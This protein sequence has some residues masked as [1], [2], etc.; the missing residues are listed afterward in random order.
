MEPRRYKTSVAMTETTKNRLETLKLRLRKAGIARGDAS[1]SAIIEILVATAD[2][3]V[4][5][6][7]LSG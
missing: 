6:D 5:L 1:E 7:N 2:F 3:D 4:L